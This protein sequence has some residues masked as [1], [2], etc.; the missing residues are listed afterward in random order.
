MNTTRFR[1]ALGVGVAQLRHAPARVLAPVAGVAMAV[2]LVTTLVGFGAG[3]LA[4]GDEALSYLEQDLWIDA[5]GD[6]AS[7]PLLAAHE[8]RRDLAGRSDVAAAAAIDVRSAT[9]SHDGTSVSLVGVG[10]A[11]DGVQVVTRDGEGLPERDVHYANGTYEGPRTDR[12]L[13]DG[14]TADRLGVS[15]GDEVTVGHASGAD[16]R[17]VTVAGISPTF[18]TFLGTPTVVLPL[19]E[20]QSL[21]GTTG[22][23]PA[24]MLGVTVADGAAVDTVESDIEAANSGLTA[25]DRQAQLRAIFRN[26][27]AVLTA[28]GTLV[29]VALLVGTALVATVE[30]QLVASQR[31]ELA[32]LAVAG[33]RR[34]TLFV[35]V[36]GQGLAMAAIGA[37]VGVGATPLAARG[38]NDLLADLTGFSNLV[39]TPPWVLAVGL[40]VALGMGIVGATAG[41]VRVLR[42]DPLERLRDG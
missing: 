9:V 20:L 8:T 42:L 32:A 12:V 31:R 40:A 14:A 7:G 37:A 25:R 26:Q 10:V 13:V 23:D 27:G 24:T 33:L 3:T 5:E 15:V 22:Q 21:A 36:L 34:R 41:G 4:A 16:G 11:G 39:R 28:L 18:R 35:T 2:L 19:S 6:G 38:L 1:A 29:T 17:T 30:G